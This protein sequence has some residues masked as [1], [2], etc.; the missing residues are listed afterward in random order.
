MARDIE[1]A[2]EGKISIDDVSS[3]IHAF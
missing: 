3:P 1:K 2:I